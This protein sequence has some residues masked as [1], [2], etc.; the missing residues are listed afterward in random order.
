[1]VSMYVYHENMTIFLASVT[2]VIIFLYIIFIRDTEKEPFGLL[3]KAFLSGFAVFLF[4]YPVEWLIGLLS[5]D[6][7]NPLTNSLFRGFVNAGLPEESLKFFLLYKVVWKEKDFDQYYDGIIYAVFVSLGFALIE[8]IV[9]V[10]E[11][12]NNWRTTAVMR[13]FTAVPGHGLF[14]V[15]MGYFF[16][17][18][19]FSSGRRRTLYLLNAV[20]LPVLLHGTYDFSLLYLRYSDENNFLFSLLAEFLFAF[21]IIY[22]WKLG[23]RNIRKHLEKDSFHL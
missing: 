16:S 19:R 9:Y 18:A 21:I 2:P 13:A 23:I 11:S 15:A 6:I 8:N 22:L 3:L 17:L 7:Q 20:G 12:G 10:L 5:N 1:M 4:A 14:A